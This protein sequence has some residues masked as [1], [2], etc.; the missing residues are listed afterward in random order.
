MRFAIG[1]LVGLLLAEAW[2]IADDRQTRAGR[3]TSALRVNR[4]ELGGP[5]APAGEAFLTKS[6]DRIV[7]PPAIEQAS[8]DIRITRADLDQTDAMNQRLARGEFILLHERPTTKK[9]LRATQQEMCEELAKEDHRLVSSLRTTLDLS[10]EDLAQLMLHR[11]KI[12]FATLEYEAASMQALDARAM[13]DRRM[14][15][16][17]TPDGYE[18]YRAIEDR[19]RAWRIYRML[20][21]HLET[22]GLGHMVTRSVENEMVEM[23]DACKMLSEDSARYTPFGALPEIGFGPAAV[24]EFLARRTASIK[25]SNDGLRVTRFQYDVPEVVFQEVIDYFDS[26]IQ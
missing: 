13:Y 18:I 26:L 22:V 4:Q 3:W 11:R 8:S 6:T 1:L 12:R 9:L 21:K 5:H 14:R 23:L 20:R 19:E 24:E 17:L 15:T 16:Q 2:R 25:S 10:D 7:S